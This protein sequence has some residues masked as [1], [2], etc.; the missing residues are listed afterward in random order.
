MNRPSP[1]RSQGLKDAELCEQ[2]IELRL[3]RAKPLACPIEFFVGTFQFQF[4][5][6]ESMFEFD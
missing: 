4:D 5:P 1:R 6:S 3:H 2:M